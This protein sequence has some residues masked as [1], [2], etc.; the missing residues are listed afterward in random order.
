MLITSDIFEPT[1]VIQH[2]FFTRLGGVSHDCFGSL[3]CG[4]QSGDTYENVDANRQRVAE[5][6]GADTKEKLLT[7]RQVH[8]NKVATLT[9]ATC[10]QTWEAPEADALVTKQPGIAIGVLTADCL[11]VLFFDPEAKVIGAAH[12]GWKGLLSGV[13]ENTMSAMM[14]LGASSKQLRV[15][16]GPSIFQQNYEVD[17]VF[18]D[19]H[20]EKDPSSVNFFLNGSK[21][22]KY[23]FDL[24]GYAQYRLQRKDVEE[25]DI[26]ERDTFA[27]PDTFFSSRYQ[28][29]RAT[30]QF[31]RQISAIILK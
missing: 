14:A 21:A 25:I 7:V 20:L 9:E 4:Y 8:G 11:P 16:I 18:H 28:V 29:P 24:Q 22:G 3:N 15:A 6:L 1:Q 19:K 26:I 17:Q 2:G 30:G 27:E 10:N 31:G 23:L 5:R 13:L 12:A